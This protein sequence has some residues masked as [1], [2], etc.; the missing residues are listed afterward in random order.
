M[1]DYTIQLVKESFDL[2][3]PMAP[4]AAAMFRQNLGQAAPTLQALMPS[5]AVG[6]Q[7]MQAV[8]QA[9][10]QLWEPEQLLPTLQAMGRHHASLMGLRDEDYDAVGGALMKTLEQGLGPAFDDETRAAW[11]DVYG[12]MAGYLKQA[13]GLDRAAA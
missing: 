5:Q 8:G 12:A 7:W 1:N 3:E 4:Q 6:E 2:V 11:I 13:G 10:R 9:I